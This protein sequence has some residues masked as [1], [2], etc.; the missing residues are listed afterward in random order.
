M[1]APIGHNSQTPSIEAAK[2]AADQ[3]GEFLR[4]TPVIE[5][6]DQCKQGD[7]WI[8][9]VR[10]AL[11][12]L[13]D[14]RKPKADPL[15]AQWKAIN[16]P[17]RLISQPLEK[18]YDVLKKRVSTF[19]NEIERQRAAEAN[20]LR[21]EAEE[22]ERIA[23]EAERKEQDAIACADVGEC[24]D[25][26][27]AIEEADEAFRDFSKAERQAAT[28]ERNVPVRVASIVG[29]KSLSMRTRRVLQIDDA[30]AAI[31]AMGVTEKIAIAIRQSAAAFE[32]AYGELPAGITETFERGM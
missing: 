15:Y 19:K 18:L 6:F 25:V 24:T 5:N 14:E 21:R 7:A 27:G 2:D 10:I 9:R 29:G 13:E 31:K 3:L 8:E 17:Y 26:G 11:A 16:E 23:R 4:E 1:L 20:R 12:S 30:C 28:A 22:R 32:D